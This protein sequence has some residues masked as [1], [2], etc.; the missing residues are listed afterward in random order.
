MLSIGSDF[1]PIV[2]KFKSGVE[3]NDCIAGQKLDHIQWG[4]NGLGLVSFGNFGK[5]GN[6]IGKTVNGVG[7]AYNCD[8][9]VY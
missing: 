5:A 9:R 6:I 3:W 7:L 1:I 2:S 4:L 8:E